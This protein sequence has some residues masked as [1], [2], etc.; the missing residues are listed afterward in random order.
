MHYKIFSAINDPNNF[1]HRQF[2][3]HCN[4][5]LSLI[6]YSRCSMIRL[7]IFNFFQGIPGKNEYHERNTELWIIVGSKQFLEIFMNIRM[8]YFMMI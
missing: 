7:F 3:N 4:F 5:P 1:V 6:I 2:H 8:I